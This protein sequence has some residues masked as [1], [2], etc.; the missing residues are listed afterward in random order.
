M[1]LMTLYDFNVSFIIICMTL[2]IHLHECDDVFQFYDFIAGRHRLVDHRDELWVIK[3][4]RL[5]R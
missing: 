5:I 4:T 3:Y 2:M 1:T